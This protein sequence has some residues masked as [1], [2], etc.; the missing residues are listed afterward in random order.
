MNKPVSLAKA[1]NFITDT[2]EHNQKTGGAVKYNFFMML[3]HFS[4]VGG[5]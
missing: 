4:R 1:D 5:R 2:N 3:V